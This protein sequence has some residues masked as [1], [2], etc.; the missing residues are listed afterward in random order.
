ML[1]AGCASRYEWVK[2]GT[3]SAARAA[4]IA[5]CG[6]KISH[7]TKDDPDAVPIVDRCMTERGYQKKKVE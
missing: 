2:A 1:L 4:D 6:G 7:L 3:P 5:G